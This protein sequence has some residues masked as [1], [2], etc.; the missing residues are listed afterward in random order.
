[1][2]LMVLRIK[3]Y[4]LLGSDGFLSTF[5]VSWD[6]HDAFHKWRREKVNVCVSY[7]FF[8]SASNSRIYKKSPE[9]NSV[10]RV[11]SKNTRIKIG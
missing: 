6:M 7:F 11:T 3:S 5:P 10:Q 8:F 2:T 1:M 9:A 4:N